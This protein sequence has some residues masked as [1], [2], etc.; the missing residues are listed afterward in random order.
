[1]KKLLS[2]IVSL[3]LFTS[4]FAQVRE[5]APTKAIGTQVQMQE[6][7]QWDSSIPE[8]CFCCN[9]KV[10]NLPKPPPITGTTL[11]CAC[12]PITFSTMNCP[13]ASYSWTV[14]DNKGNVISFTANATGNS[15]KLSYSLAQ[16]MASGASGFVVTVEI[17]CGNK[18]VKN[19]IKVPMKPIPPTNISFTLTDDGAGN[20]KATANAMAPATSNGNGWALKEAPCPGP[21]PCAWVYGSIVWQSTGNSVTIPSGV[22]AKGKCYVLVHYVNVCSPTWIAGPC[23]VYKATCFQL[24]GNLKMGKQLDNNNEV[25]VVTQEMMKDIIGIKD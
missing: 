14:T 12:D 23:T 16:Q 2:I 22:L 6:D 3:M 17:R 4:V 10:Y 13:G 21:N 18:I 20:Y 15:I 1:M 19:T 25:L 11:A 8:E 24:N 7:I 5:E 9:E